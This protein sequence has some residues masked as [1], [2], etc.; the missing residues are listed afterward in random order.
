LQGWARA[1]TH[2]DQPGGSHTSA[3]R[4]RKGRHRMSATATAT[5]S[6]ADSTGSGSG[7]AEPQGAL[8]VGSVG[9]PDTEAVLRTAAEALGDRLR[10]VPDG[11]TGGRNYWSNFRTRRFDTVPQLERV[12]EPGFRI[13]EFDAR[14]LRFKD[15]VDPSAVV[16]PDLGYAQAAID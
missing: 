11:E 9:L 15:G 14:P 6:T 3:R 1:A 13:G 10:G 8:L 4:L 7:A 16:L 5:T 2:L 12:G